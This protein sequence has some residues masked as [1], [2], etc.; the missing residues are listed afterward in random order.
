LNHTFALSQ[1]SLKI[2]KSIDV[3]NETVESVK[4]SL[5][6]NKLNAIGPS[7][8][9]ESSCDTKINES[10]AQPSWKK[11]WTHNSP[12]VT[13]SPSKIDTLKVSL[14][15]KLEKMGR[16]MFYSG[17]C[18]L[19]CVVLVIMLALAVDRRSAFMYGF[20]FLGILFS[21]QIGNLLQLAAIRTSIR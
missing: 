12:T 13:K 4:R 1:V 3:D 5:T 10:S 15:I 18:T 14:L 21:L 8:T 19:C 11:T 17:C 9:K 2:A 7:P 20:V 6:H 16:Y